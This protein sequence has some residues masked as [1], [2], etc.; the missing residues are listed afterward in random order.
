M[1][2]RT[3][4]RPSVFGKNVTENF[5]KTKSIGVQRSAENPTRVAQLVAESECLLRTNKKDENCSLDTRARIAM[6]KARVG[7][8]AYLE[9]SARKL[10]SASFKPF[11]TYGSK[12]DGNVDV[13]SGTRNKEQ[14]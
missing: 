1:N 14:E 8:D 4:N 9:K 11:M 5:D 13:G 12:M 7:F 2:A 6:G 10:A 3:R